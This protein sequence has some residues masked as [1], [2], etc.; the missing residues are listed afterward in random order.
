MSVYYAQRFWLGI[1][2]SIAEMQDP[3][4]RHH[5]VEL[6]RSARRCDRLAGALVGGIVTMA[7]VLLV[8]WLS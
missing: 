1:E 7:A 3:M 4:V 5:A 2:R 8:R 6:V